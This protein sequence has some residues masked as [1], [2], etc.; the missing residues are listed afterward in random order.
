MEESGADGGN[1]Y[2]GDGRSI[3]CYKTDEWQHL[4]LEWAAVYMVL[5][6]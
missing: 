6:S 3:G 5:V 2:E 4:P 1:R